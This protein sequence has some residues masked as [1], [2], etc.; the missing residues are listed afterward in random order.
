MAKV[1]IS[2]LEVNTELSRP[3]VK[4]TVKKT[5]NTGSKVTKI[6]TTKSKNTTYNPIDVFVWNT[7]QDPKVKDS[8]RPINVLDKQPD[9]H[10]ARTIESLV[11]QFI[12]DPIFKV[13]VK[14]I[15]NW[16]VI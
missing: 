8:D 14:N 4:T 10:D 13:T 3:K 6:K 9:E 7:K 5:I 2:Q 1:S 16:Y 15:I 11:L 12:E